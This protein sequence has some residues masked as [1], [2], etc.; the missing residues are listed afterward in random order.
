MDTLVATTTAGVPTT[1]RKLYFLRFAFAAVWA[2]L[3]FTAAGTLGPLSVSLLLVYPLFDVAAAVVDAR[4]ATANGATATPLF[5]NI[6]ISSL[7]VIGL[8]VAAASGVP[9][10]LRVWGTWAVAA[11]LVQLIAAVARRTLGGQWAMITSGALS[12]VAGLS[13]VV[14]AGG[15]APSLKNVAGYAL[16]GGVFFL[17]SAVRLNSAARH[18]A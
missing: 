16:L 9:A 18:Q 2:L 3:L 11:G 7:A 5:A 17:V 15:E 6:V 12:T 1:L 10:V 8:A 14:Q 4:A 13:F